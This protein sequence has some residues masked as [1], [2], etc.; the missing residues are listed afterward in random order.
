LAFSQY[1]SFPD[2]C[3]SLRCRRGHFGDI[4]NEALIIL[5]WVANWRPIGFR[6]LK[7]APHPNESTPREK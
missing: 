7:T 1:A 5:G 2:A 4:L 3:L 6:R